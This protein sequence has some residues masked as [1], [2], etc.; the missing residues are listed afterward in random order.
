MSA[1]STKPGF[2]EAANAAN[3]F[4]F[5]FD[6]VRRTAGEGSVHQA[7]DLL[8]V[9]SVGCSLCLLPTCGHFVSCHSDCHLQ[10]QSCVRIRLYSSSQSH[11]AQWVEDS[12]QR[13]REELW[14]R[15]GEEKTLVSIERMV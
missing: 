9:P 1:D 3:A 15:G 12:R 2:A 6:P 4:D 11:L 7:G 10:T 8:P 14:G 5:P 13:C